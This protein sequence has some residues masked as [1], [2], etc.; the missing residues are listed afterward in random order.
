MI[1]NYDKVANIYAKHD[2]V[3]TAFLA[4]KYTEDLISQYSKGKKTLDYG[5]GSG[6]STRFLKD[7]GLDVI[8]V[9][10]N[11][12]MLE[13]ATSFNDGI[14]YKKIESGCIPYQDQT[15][16][17]IFSAFV[18]FEIESKEKMLSVIN[19]IYRVLENG[20]VFVAITGST[21]MYHYPWLSL[22]TDFIENKN[23]VS[24][25]IAKVHLKEVDL[26]VYDYYWTD[27][28][29]RDVFRQSQ[30][31]LADTI[32]PLG[33]K[34]DPYPWVTEEQKSPYVIYVLTKPS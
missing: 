2:N 15:F 23:L 6:S 11:S 12:T 22:E 3:G 16:N 26:T 30:F 13:E 32:Y 21:D 34:S 28:D 17:I 8:G 18:L 27:E 5:C 9:D 7:I 14:P 33:H 20:G 29:Y 10:I 25:A 19:E 1:N 31:H 24:G 4:F